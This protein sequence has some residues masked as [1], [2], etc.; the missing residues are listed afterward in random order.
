MLGG[1]SSIHGATSIMALLGDFLVPVF[2]ASV[3]LSSVFLRPYFWAY[4]WAWRHTG[5]IGSGTQKPQKVSDHW[6]TGVA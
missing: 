4:I 2:L 3:F 6:L 1:P 5:A